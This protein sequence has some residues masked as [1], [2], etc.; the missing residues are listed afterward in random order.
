MTDGWLWHTLLSG[1]AIAAGSRVAQRALRKLRRLKVS[2]ELL[3]TV[4]IAGALL[5]GEFTEAA[6]VA[7]LFILGERLEAR[8]LSRQDWMRKSAVMKRNVAFVESAGAGETAK[9]VTVL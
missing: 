8:A 3:V 2:I 6:V 7:A 9:P 1:M 5:L 4:A